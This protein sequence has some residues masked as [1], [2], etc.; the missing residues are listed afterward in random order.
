MMLVRSQINAIAI[1][2]LF[3]AAAVQGSAV[4]VPVG[5]DGA[6]P[7]GWRTPRMVDPI[8]ENISGL[9]CATATFCRA[10][11]AL[12]SVYTGRPGHWTG[13]RWTGAANGM[14]VISCPQ[15]R[16]CAALD[17]KGG[18]LLNL[19]SGWSS[20]GQ[21]FPGG[22]ATSLSC[23]SPTFCAAVGFLNG[24]TDVASTWDGTSWSE[25]QTLEQFP[26]AVSCASS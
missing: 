25:T 14:F 8:A 7:V 24:G 19:G 2:G 18:W 17:E 6:A 26:V 3:V 16:F 21:V 23:A 9:D 10:Y 11:D 20:Q 5:D 1:A 15:R 4:A 12:G 13:P 22:Y